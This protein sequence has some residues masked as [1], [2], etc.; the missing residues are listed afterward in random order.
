MLKGVR[1]PECQYCWNVEDLGPEHY[2]DR[3]SKS[4]ES[5]AK[6][7]LKE[8]ANMVGVENVNPT[9]VEVS[10]SNVCNLKCSYCSPAFSSSWME[11][12]QSEGAYP[13]SDNFN[14][15]HWLRKE[16]KLPI[17]HREHNPYVDA[18]WKWFPDLYKTLQVFRITGGEPLLTKDT[19]KV[20]DYINNNPRPELELAINS[21][22]C[23]PDKLFDQYIEK[24][25]RIT[26]DNKI[27]LTRLYTSV[28]TFGKQAEYIRDGLDFNQWYNNICR[29]LTELPKTKVTIMCTTGLLSLP[30]FH[31]LV[32]MIHPLKREFYSNERRVPITLDTAILR[33]PSYL[34]GVVADPSYAEMLEPALSVMNAN[35]ET[36]DN[37]Y[38]GF[39]DF[40]IAKLKRFQQYIAA[41][42]NPQEKLNIQQVRRDFASYV[43]EYDRRRNKDFL[44]TF[45]ELEDFYNLCK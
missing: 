23:V 19:F 27:G 37:A 20:L 24:M 6:P 45:P 8:T 10:F 44:K 30:N 39:F 29:V 5:W 21:N 13:T 36:H 9:Y 18:F 42:P 14:N 2:S 7:F 38:K 22:G 40:E 43:D 35:A 25:K 11:E 12:I 3:S 28:D 34:S 26:L 17:P 16:G 41:G 31:K 4:H 33:H 32:D 1:P 15:L